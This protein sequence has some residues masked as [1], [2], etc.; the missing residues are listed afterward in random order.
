MARRGGEEEWKCRNKK[1]VRQRQSNRYGATPLDYRAQNAHELRRTRWDCR[2]H[3]ATGL[4]NTRAAAPDIRFC[5]LRAPAATV[6]S[7]GEYCLLIYSFIS[8]FPTA[9]VFSHGR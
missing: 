8:V 9:V 1:N 6:P 4:W 2:C 5:P 3:T 7:R